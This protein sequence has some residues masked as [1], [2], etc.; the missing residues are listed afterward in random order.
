MERRMACVRFPAAGLAVLLLLMLWPG[1]RAKT[2]GVQDAMAAL[3]LTLAESYKKIGEN[4][5]LYTQRFGADPGVMEYDGRLYVY[6]TDDVVEYEVTGQVRENTYSKIRHINCISSGDLVN[7]TDHGRIP[8]AGP[9]GIAASWAKNSWAPCAAH[10]TVDGREKFF[11]YFCN[12]GNGIGVLCAD[13]PT[14]PWRDELGH[15][16]ITRETPNCADVLWLFDPAV[17]VDE[18]GTGY[19]AFGGGVPE[20]RQ[21]N[22]G[23]GRIVRLGP[24]MM[25]LDGDPVK[26]EVPWLFEDSGINRI[27]D[28]YIYSYCSNWQTDGNDLGLSNGAIQYMVADDPLGP[29]TYAGE[30]FPNEG[31]FFG[32]WGNNHHSIASLNGEWFLFYH[33]RPVE[34]AMG[35][36]GNYRSPQ[37]DRLFLEED[38][39]LRSVI[40]TMAGLSQIRPLD[41]MQE[42]SATTLANQ[43]GIAVRMKDGKTWVHGEAGSWTMVSGV[44]FGAGTERLRLRVASAEGGRIHLV[45]GSLQD[46]IAATLQIPAETKE[47][48]DFD[49]QVALTGV[50]DVY[51]VFEGT[52][53]FYAWQAEE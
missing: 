43:G 46:P 52:L 37:A 9:G 34:Q 14:G 12:G 45:T 33:S 5:P 23:T 25:S 49:L 21:A 26:L 30:L 39:S 20:G 27:G 13:S 47:P 3:H 40:G 36:T 1:M 41:P 4:N 44:D 38:G 32:L 28:R 29:Y 19:L 16:L 11:L 8:V 7:W 2:E 31:K 6:M 15:L 10:K 48:T 53:D 24:D 18:D 17:M 22:P 42:V 35:I 50:T 51:F